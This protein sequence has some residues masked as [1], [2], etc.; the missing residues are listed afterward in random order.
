MERVILFL[1]ISAAVGN[2]I[3]V[4][5]THRPKTVSEFRMA[6]QRRASFGKLLG[7]QSGVFP[8]LLLTDAGDEEYFGEV[9]IGTPPQKFTVIYDTGSSNLWIPSKS[10][11][12]CK[13]GSPR[14][15][16]SSSS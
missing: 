3:K 15:E 5:L 14:Y 13:S 2:V 16:S 12:N 10:C 9:D 8:A 1:T 4:P 11:T 6:S 7:A